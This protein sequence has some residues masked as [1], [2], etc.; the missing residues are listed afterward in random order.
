MQRELPFILKDAVLDIQV[1]AAPPVVG[2]TQGGSPISGH[3]WPP[4]CGVGDVGLGAGFGVG[5]GLGFGNGLT[6]PGP[7][8][9]T[10]FGT[11][12]G[13]RSGTGGG[14]GDGPISGGGLCVGL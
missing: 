3:P 12:F 8:T 13:G 10:G 14:P 9:G 6:N 5:I 11:G 1:N 4:G 2:S 7:G